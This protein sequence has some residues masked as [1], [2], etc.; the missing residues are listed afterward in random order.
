MSSNDITVENGQTVIT[1]KNELTIDN[2]RDIHLLLIEAIDMRHP[3][4][5]DLSKAYEFDVS[6]LQLLIS[7]SKTLN[8][9]GRTLTLRHDTLPSTFCDI[10]KSIGCNCTQFCSGFTHNGAD[11]NSNGDSSISPKD[12]TP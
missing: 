8:A 2:A 6:F 4:I 1:L 3:L 11:C 9:G 10:A 5:I 7:C 12:T